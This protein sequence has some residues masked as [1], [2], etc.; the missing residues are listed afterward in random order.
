MAKKGPEKATAPSNP[1]EIEHKAQKDI[2]I[3][4]FQNTAN[5]FALARALA[6]TM[7]IECL[8]A[9]ELRRLEEQVKLLAQD[10]RTDKDKLAQKLILIQDAENRIQEIRAT[11]ELI[12]N[13]IL[14]TSTKDEA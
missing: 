13:K 6:N 11:I 1:A 8:T 12:S 3:R 5:Q 2:G 10:P 14:E 7:E 9:D 4:L